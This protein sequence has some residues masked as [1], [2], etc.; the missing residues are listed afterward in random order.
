M[1]VHLSLNQI[2]GLFPFEPQSLSRGMGMVREK[3][4]AYFLL[5]VSKT[6]DLALAW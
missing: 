5:R 6:G 2:G 1:T 4:N 3:D